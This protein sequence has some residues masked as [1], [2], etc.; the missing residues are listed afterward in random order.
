MDISDKADF[1]KMTRSLTSPT[2]LSAAEHGRALHAGLF[3]EEYAADD[4]TVTTATDIYDI[5]RELKPAYAGYL[6]AGRTKR[7]GQRKPMKGADFS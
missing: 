3:E 5:G 1:A 7:I 4:V 2:T 6:R